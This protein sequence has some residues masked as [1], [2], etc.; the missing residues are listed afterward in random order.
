MSADDAL[1]SLVGVD[2]CTL[3][4]RPLADL[5][6]DPHDARALASCLGTLAA[7]DGAAHVTLGVRAAGGNELVVDLV[8]SP[9]PAG[10]ITAVVIDRT[11]ATRARGLLERDHRRW[12]SLARNAADI[13]F[14]T[15]SVGAITTI[16][17]TLPQRLGWQ[18]EE[19]IGRTGVSFVHPDDQHIAHEA[20]VDIAKGVD[21]QVLREVRLQHAD[22][23][24]TWARIVVSDMRHDPDVAAIVCNVTDIS[25]Q[26]AEEARHQHEEHRYR[27][28][29][30][31]SQ[32]PQ[33]MV[34]IDGRYESVNDALCALLGRRR[35]EMLGR[36]PADFT[37]PDDTG[38][39]DN[40]LRGVLAGE[41]DVMRAV[42]VFQDADGRPIPVI[43]DATVLR[44]ENDVPN[45]CAAV[46]Q[47]LRPLRN[48]EMARA[49]QEQ[50]FN[51]IAERSTDF[52]MVFDDDLRLRYAS[53]IGERM[54][55][56]STAST[57]GQM[58]AYVH[59]EDLADVKE[60]WEASLAGHE[61]RTWRFR[62]R[63]V[64]GS[65][66]WFEQ[67]STNLLDTGIA[68]VVSNV[69]DVTP[70]V[71]AL[72][73]LR[74]SEARYRAMAE[75]AEEGLLVISPTGYV[76][77]A[78]ARV[79]SLLGLELGYI[80]SNP[81]W[82]VLDPDTASQVHDKV[83]SRARRGSERYEVP[84]A[85]PDGTRRTLW[86]SA[87]PMP[88]VEG[89]PQ[90]SLAMISDIT[91]SRRSESALRHAALHDLLTGLP[92]RA[93]LMQCLE[94][95]DL[96][97]TGT[98]LLFVDLDHF[99]DVNDGR[100][101]T[102]GDEVLVAV[103]ERLLTACEAIDVVQLVARF[104]GDEFV[105]VLH[106]ADAAIAVDV[107]EEVR[108][109]LAEPYVVGSRGVR[110][111]ASIGV[112]LTP[113][114][115]ADDL[116]RFADTAM[117]A[118]KAGGR[119]RV[120][121]FDRAL[122]EQA[123]ERYVLGA[124]LVA[125][126]AGDG[127]HMAYQPVITLET[128]AVAG[129]EALARWEHPTRGNIPPSRF[130]ALA[131]LNGSASELDRW[132]IRRAMSD[133]ASLKADG[134]MDPGAYV[135][136]NLSGQSLSDVGL[137][138]FIAQCADDAGLSPDTIGLEITESA[139]MADKDVAIDVLERLRARG[140]T[141]A[142][143]DFGTGYSSMA[144]LRDLPISVLKIDRGFV[145][146]IPGD[147]HSR[148]IVTSLIQLAHSMGL[149]VIAEGVEEPDQLGELKAQRC[150]LA[151]GWLWSPA[152]TAPELRASGA[153]LR[154]HNVRT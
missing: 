114:D 20:W 39:A 25:R 147:Q 57:P 17:S 100:G 40:A 150:R 48:S 101:H 16:T 52:V 37:H 35:D 136:I 64:D 42:R 83:Q 102:A 79:A 127:L 143:D 26:K 51:V 21:H 135:G 117:Y 89:R 2:A 140:F 44:D 69:R 62:A 5:L 29:F 121:L 131:E 19:V 85:H 8:C 67:T 66:G 74:V 94:Q 10:A 13:M 124:E 70:E 60:Q 91:D 93:C 139:I 15:D 7:G 1:G 146:G 75:T 128:G 55:G 3:S 144:Y 72:E 77:Y 145:C 118:A 31:H 110:V 113:A 132:V 105:L 56:V 103:A 87:S 14:T 108:E 107:A 11:Q 36:R 28:R 61:A 154:R 109:A 126:L 116:L 151:Q 49:Q 141:I 142:I 97:L 34:C 41:S 90:G 73:A 47:D 18:V 54:F 23:T 106:G 24:I 111:G 119:G 46:L 125:A 122:A 138:A 82:T 50:L 78:N 76:T 129:V 43:V 112:A 4:G 137:D 80:Y 6:T 68:G 115:S 63:R 88:D 92:N 123:E 59:P 120:R 38:V 33:S 149:T 71:Q 99:K 153:L 104:G 81:V 45:G 53:P 134:S 95:E 148:A 133:V 58:W 152:R 32:L 9:G 22:G 96:A 84:Y 65:W 12:L 86:V 98:A 27:A 130:I 30:D